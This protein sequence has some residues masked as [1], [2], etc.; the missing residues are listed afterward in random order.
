MKSGSQSKRLFYQNDRLVSSLV[1][2][3]KVRYFLGGG[4]LLSDL[5][6]KASVVSLLATESGGTVLEDLK[7]GAACRVTYAPYGQRAPDF[8]G[9]TQL[10]FNGEYLLP[11][12]ACYG[13]GN[14]YRF[15]SPVLMRFSSP[16]NWAP[17][18][19][20]HAY[21]Y[22]KGDPVN[23]ADP[24][25]HMLSKHLR[26]YQS[27]TNDIVKRMYAMS[28]QEDGFATL[29]R[30]MLREDLD[31]RRLQVLKEIYSLYD[32]GRKSVV[33]LRRHAKDPR[34]K[35]VEVRSLS[36]V[37]NFKFYYS[38]TLD[39]IN[40]AYLRHPSVALDVAIDRNAINGSNIVGPS[41]QSRSTMP[42]GVVQ[43]RR[44]TNSGRRTNNLR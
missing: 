11:L 29:P 9:M 24:S 41:G 13:L 3:L 39:R 18:R 21:G 7:S 1:L 44:A 10:G 26:R 38:E 32:A 12:L 34:Y 22:C 15:F 25:G 2:G 36:V 20:L 17:F 8:S 19:V 35:E 43:I 42:S 6:G 28:Y 40:E 30:N 31:R 37:E 27:N 23:H 5:E 33:W 4:F 16:D 14:G